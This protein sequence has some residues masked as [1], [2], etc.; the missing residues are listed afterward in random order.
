MDIPIVFEDADI[1]VVDKP[2][3]LTVNRSENEEGLTLQDW[4]EK[5]LRIKGEG[6]F[7][8]RAGIVHRL[9]KETSG[10]L[11][12]AKNSD[13]F[14][15][16]QKQF[17]LR[18]IFK[19]YLAL[20]HGEII[21][22]GEIKLPVG[23]LPSNRRKFGIVHTGREA[24]TSFKLIKKYSRDNKKYSF[25]EVIPYTG[26]THQIRIHLKYIGFTICGDKLYTDRREYSDDMTFCKRLFLH[27]SILRFTHPI[28]DQKIE[29]ESKLPSELI[30]VLN[31][32][33]ALT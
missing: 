5:R 11:I 32:L 30:Q 27:A 22:A 29:V 19:L 26:R 18:S 14:Y 16:L 6:E 3:H 28:T 13:S 2:A 9:D 10:L 8:N 20:V 33:T 15:S 24:K 7:Y 12:V 31:K 4:T 25:I 21:Q 17:F 23:R 1:L